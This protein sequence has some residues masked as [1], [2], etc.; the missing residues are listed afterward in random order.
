MVFGMMFPTDGFDQIAKLQLVAGDLVQFVLFD[1][2][3]DEIFFRQ[4]Q[5]MDV[6]AGDLSAEK[7]KNVLS[8]LRINPLQSQNYLP[9]G[10]GKIF[11]R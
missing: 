5:L 10:T 4:Q 1:D 11:L 9:S 2:G 6:G 8:A 3:Q 7:E